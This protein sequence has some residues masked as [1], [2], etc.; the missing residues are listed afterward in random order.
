MPNVEEKAVTAGLTNVTVTTT[1]ETQIGTAR[2]TVPLATARILA[3]AWYVLT[4]GTATT[5]IT[6]RIRRGIGLTGAVLNDA[7]A[8][9]VKAA[10]GSSE[11][12]LAG[13]IVDVQD[14]DFVEVTL[15][16]QQ[17]AA[18]GNGTVTEFVLEVEVLNG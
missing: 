7:V 11:S 13:A 10:A 1:S 2:V 18:T 4:T 15:S 6:T 14:Q 17:A 16:T 9:A 8:E 12:C 3:K 5:T